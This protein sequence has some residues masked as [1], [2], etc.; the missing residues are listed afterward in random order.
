V[1]VPAK[2]PLVSEQAALLEEAQDGVVYVRER[3]QLL[4]ETPLDRASALE[5][6]VRHQLHGVLGVE[7]HDSVEVTCVVELDVAVE[8]LPVIT[9]RASPFGVRPAWER[10]GRARRA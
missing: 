4:C 3:G 9:H 1:C 6:A 5:G 8:D 10:G 2:K 7:V